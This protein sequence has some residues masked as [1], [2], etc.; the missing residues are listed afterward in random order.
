MSAKGG[1]NS[2]T[3]R[4][5][6]NWKVVILQVSAVTACRSKRGNAEAAE[7]GR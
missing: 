5:A 2:E 4:L 3:V 7:L 1:E 6:V